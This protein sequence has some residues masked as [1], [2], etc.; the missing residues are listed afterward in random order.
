[1][2]LDVPRSVLVAY[3][4]TNYICTNALAHEVRPA[5]LQ[6]KEVAHNRFS[7]LWKKPAV[8]E[9][10]IHLMP[11]ISNGLLSSA[12]DAEYS[13]TAFVIERWTD[14]DVPRRSFEGAQLTIEG[15]DRTMTDVLL[16][17]EFLSGLK[18]QTVIEPKRPEYRFHLEEMNN[19][20]M[21]AYL[22][23][24]VEHI[25]T[26]FDHLGFVLAL[27]MLVQGIRNLIRTITAFTIAHSIT[28]AAAVLGYVN[29]NPA[30]VESLVALSV[31]FVAVEVTRLLRGHEGLTT[32]LPW[33]IAFVFGLLHGL[34]FAGSIAAVGFP[35]ES[36]PFALFL[37]NVGVEVG[38]VAF[39]CGITLVRS[40][41]SRVLLPSAFGL[42]RWTVVYGL[43]ISSSYWV[44]DRLFIVAQ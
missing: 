27:L 6:I 39:V 17:A 24:G 20:G 25:L 43:G 33:L 4:F 32:R 26:G 23:L 16:T 11:R 34:A 2:L 42:A 40:I 38:Q 36:I 15:L 13:T 18:I 44:L 28:L 22:W 29:C 31:F 1:M 3:L 41:F 8:G 21:P 7:V 12:P 30:L 5:Y 9:F 10:S 37:F 14:R 19:F 35:P